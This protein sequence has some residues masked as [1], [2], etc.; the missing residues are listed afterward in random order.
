MTNAIYNYTNNVYG[1]M[2]NNNGD[3]T[4]DIVS[5][6]GESPVNKTQRNIY[7]V[8]ITCK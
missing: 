3:P 1:L 6:S 8:A 2:G 5:R 4:D 7:N